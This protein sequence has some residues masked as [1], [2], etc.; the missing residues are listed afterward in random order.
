[1]EL[2]QLSVLLSYFLIYSFIGW[3]LE[4]VYK[5]IL[6]R[7]FVNSGFV[8]GPFCPIYGFGAVIL[9][10]FLDG[11]KSNFIFVFM[12][13]TIVFSIWEYIV[14]L[15]LEKT[16]NTKYWD[17]SNEKFNFQGRLC[18]FMSLTWGAL[19]VLFTYVLHPFISSFLL[20]IPINVLNPVMALILI[21][22]IVDFIVS[23]IKV[24][25]ID[26]RVS[27]LKEI[28]NILNAKSDEIKALKIKLSDFNDIKLFATKNVQLNSLKQTIE[29]L[30]RKE[31]ILKYKLNKRIVKMKKAFPTMKSQIITEFLNQ[32]IDSIKREK[33]ER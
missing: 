26:I 14:G 6:Q 1:M 29:E 11:F 8:N 22:L 18:L 7:K 15:F 4:T 3:L 27:K 17:Y 20:K 24:K 12:I 25:N 10:L 23:A 28:Q 9:Y 31:N 16:F 30:K 19:G 21:Y 2:N 5:S 13:G 32:K 33:K